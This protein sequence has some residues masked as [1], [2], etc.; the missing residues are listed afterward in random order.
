MATIHLK[1]NLAGDF[2]A[3][4][5]VVSKAKPKPIIVPEVLQ[6][7]YLAR[8]RIIWQTTKDSETINALKIKY[9][10]G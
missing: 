1:S 10:V 8:D 3:P 4:D 7:Y 2:I 5:K 6:A 9:N